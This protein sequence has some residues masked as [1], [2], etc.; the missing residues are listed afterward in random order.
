MGVHATITASESH[1][2]PSKKY[3]TQQQ[4]GLLKVR[5]FWKIY[6]FTVFFL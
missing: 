6:G 2:V 3:K 1:K 4:K 5:L